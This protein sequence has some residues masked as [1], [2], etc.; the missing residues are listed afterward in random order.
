MYSKRSMHRADVHSWN[1]FETRYSR[2]TRISGFENKRILRSWIISACRE[3]ENIAGRIRDI[4]EWPGH[5]A[6]RPC[7]SLIGCE[8]NKTAS[9]PWPVSQGWRP[10]VSTSLS[11]VRIFSFLAYSTIDWK[12]M[13]PI[14]R[15]SRLLTILARLPGGGPPP[16]PAAPFSF[17]RPLSF[18]R[19]VSFHSPTVAPPDVCPSFSIRADNKNVWYIF[20][21]FTRWPA[22]FRV[23]SCVV[24]AR[25]RPLREEHVWTELLTL[26]RLR[27]TFFGL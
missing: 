6:C 27:P 18:A 3:I 25:Y 22:M 13:P 10:P 19:F 15:L 16:C 1:L 7:I 2:R 8:F 20:P 14:T 5:R 21:V 24:S 12:H 4:I 11:L 17:A 23:I 9:I 26:S